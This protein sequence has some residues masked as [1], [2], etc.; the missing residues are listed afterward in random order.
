MR[1]SGLLTFVFSGGKMTTAVA[2]I[3]ILAPLAARPQTSV[4]TQQKRHSHT[5]W[6]PDAKFERDFKVVLEMI[7]YFKILVEFS[8]KIR[9]NIFE[10]KA[11][12]SMLIKE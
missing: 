5:I 9:F 11:F 1:K 12:L 10:I 6:Y 8:D 7:F 2:R 4:S 3:R